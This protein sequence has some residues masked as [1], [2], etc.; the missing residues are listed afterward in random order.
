MNYLVRHPID[1]SK[2][3]RFESMCHIS[4]S[5]T[6]I[7]FIAKL[8]LESS[9]STSSNDF[10]ACSYSLWVYRKFPS[11]NNFVNCSAEVCSA[12]VVIVLGK[13]ENAMIIMQ[14]KNILKACTTRYSSA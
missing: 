1:L 8:L 10:K 14:T 9:A 5:I 13:T 12:A 7:L 2:Y 3:A 4:K 11:W 6:P